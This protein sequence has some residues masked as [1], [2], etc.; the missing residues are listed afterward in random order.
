M[1][2]PKHTVL[3]TGA[4]GKFGRLLTARL[5]G[6]G[7]QVVG[8]SRSRDS[9]DALVNDL[10][11]ESVDTSGFEG[12][13]AEFA[14]AEAVS[15][16]LSQVDLRKVTA[17][18]NNA[19]SLEHL[20][21]EPDG[22]VTHDNFMQEYR[23][24]VVVP[25]EL[26]MRLAQSDSLSLRQVINIGSQYG[27]VAANPAL[28]DE[29]IT[30]SPIQYSVAKA[31]LVHLTKELGVRLAKRQVQVNCISYGGI[32]GRVDETFLTRYSQLSPIGRMLCPR[33]VVEP[34]SMLLSHPNM[35]MTGQ[36]VHADGGWSLW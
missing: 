35:S 18:V 3:L 5:L 27:T 10:N 9:L 7:H 31:A 13:V 36:T 30:D 29:P 20:R 16:L 8:T 34:V 11:G 21:T 15:V 23:M 22:V 28:Y 24:D 2:A 33:E 14:S 6:D 26:T 4:T 25:Y 32:T 1:S 19:R 12:V 17:L